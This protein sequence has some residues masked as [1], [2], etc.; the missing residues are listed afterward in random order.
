MLSSSV[1]LKPAPWPWNSPPRHRGP[2][3]PGSHGRSPCL[4]CNRKLV[5]FYLS[6]VGST[7]LLHRDMR[8]L[9][10]EIISLASFSLPLNAFAAQPEQRDPLQVRPPR[11]HFS[12]PDGHCR[13]DTG[14]VREFHNDGAGPSA[15]TVTLLTRRVG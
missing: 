3:A 6:D 8:D 5:D 1:A 4:V 2:L 14:I 9:T 7:R 13:A 15:Q 12:G 10:L 11:R